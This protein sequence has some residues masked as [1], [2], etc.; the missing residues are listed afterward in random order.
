MSVTSSAIH[1]DAEP[2]L[3]AMSERGDIIRTMQRAMSG[4]QFELAVF[5]AGEDGR[6]IVG[7]VVEGVGRRAVRQ[8]LSGHPRN[9]R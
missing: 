7:R 6:A 8:G 1:A 5:Q 9:R 3:R 2:T 4:R